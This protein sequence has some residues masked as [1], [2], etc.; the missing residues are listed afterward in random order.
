MPKEARTK[1]KEE[2]IR[3]EKNRLSRIFRELPEK[4]KKLAIGLIERAAFMRVELEDLEA[5]LKVNGWIESFQQSEKVEPYD[6]Q[7][8]AGQ[9]YLSM[10]KNYRDITRQLTDLLP[11]K[12][13]ADA[14]PFDEF[15]GERDQL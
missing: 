11:A 10:A 4:K 14:D 3:G 8:P 7:R 2:R 9:T 6:R 15:L 1:T 13:E 12:T 5:D